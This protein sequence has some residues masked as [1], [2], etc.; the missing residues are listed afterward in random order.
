MGYAEK[1]NPK[2][3][4]NKARQ[5]SV[6]SAVSVQTTERKN[7]IQATTPPKKD[8]PVVFEFSIKG[9]WEFLCR[10]LNL[11]NKNQPQSLEPTS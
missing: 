1:N 2:S 7:F 6:D 8:E 10:R 3:K 4:W 11:T 9:L 5:G